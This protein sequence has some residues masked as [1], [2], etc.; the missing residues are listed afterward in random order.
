M[1]RSQRH[2]PRA[3]AERNKVVIAVVALAVLVTAFV[4]TMKAESLPVIGAGDSHEVYLAEAGGLKKG[5]EVRVAG[6]KVGKVTGIALEGEKVKVTFRAK[7][8]HLGDQTRASVKIK[9]LLGR[10]YLALNPAGTAPL[11]GPI[12]LAHTTTPYDVNAAFEDLST[13]VG[14]IDTDQL[15]RSLDVLSDAFKDT[16]ASVRSMVTGLTAL[17]KTVSSRD[18]QLAR[19][20]DESTKVT[21]TIADHDTDLASLADNGDKLLAELATRRKAIHQ[22]LVGTSKLGTQVRGLIN[23]N[24]K[25]L[26]PALAKLDKV[27]KILNDNQDNLDTSLRMLA[28]Y[29]R[30]LASAMGNGRWADAY[31]CGLFDDTG[32]P[33]LDNDVVR[34]CHPGGA[35]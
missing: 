19:L 35:K 7:G 29:Y 17:S 3:F 10:K 21:D 28:P 30:M 27:A 6:V 1:S 26:A 4:L 11:D 23:D 13:T 5:N 16:P 22:M 20:F 34:N 25:Q 12:P 9:T 14:S 8:V 2:Y 31:L 15:S 32:A 18:K 24:E 33:V